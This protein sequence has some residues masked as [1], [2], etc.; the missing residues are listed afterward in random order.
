[1]LGSSWVAAQLAVSQ[2][3][4][5]SMS[6]WEWVSDSILGLKKNSL[7]LKPESYTVL[8]F[9]C[10]WINTLYSLFLVMFGLSL[11]QFRDYFSCSLKETVAF[12]SNN[13]RLAFI[14]DT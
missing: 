10:E 13:N 7:Q 1:M 14:G 3:G 5:G 11:T 4:L 12:L 2:E 8:T 9:L 6:E